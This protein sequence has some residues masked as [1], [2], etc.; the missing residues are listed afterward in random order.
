ME[1][2]SVYGYD[3][4][5]HEQHRPP[6]TKPLLESGE[7]PTSEEDVPSPPH[8]PP[9]SRLLALPAELRAQ[10]LSHLLPRSLPTP[11]HPGA[12]PSASPPP[13]W[14]RGTTAIL[15]TCRLLHAEGLPFL[16]SHNTFALDV[17]WDCCTFAYRY[18][19]RS[20]TAHPLIA[21]RTMAFPDDLAPRNVA[22]MRKFHVRVH[23]VDSY[24]GMMK[25]GYGGSGLAEGLADQVRWLG[26]ILGRLERI[27]ELR[28]VWRDD[29]GREGVGEGA[30]GPL[31]ALGNV[32]RCVV[33]GEWRGKGA[34]M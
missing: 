14:L 33:E 9:T 19:S 31:R 27:G 17:V 13:V 8:P 1:P 22:L 15:A 5:M 7:D 6:P 32:E 18:I 24:L 20:A 23:H 25:Y 2:L 3:Q 26:R 29:G 28:V 30:V 34:E 16:Y 12:S 4:R 10:I 11:H 21:P